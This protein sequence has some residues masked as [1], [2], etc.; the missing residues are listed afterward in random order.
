M[1]PR[2]PLTIAVTVIAYVVTTFAVQGTSHFAINA[3]HYHAI[4][5]MRSEPIVAMGLLSMVIQGLL[6]ALLFPTF[7]RG[8]NPVRSG[9]LFSWAL[10]GFL[11]S[12][13]VLGEAG[14]YAVPSISSWI[15]VEL[16]VALV[17]YTV[18]GAL[19]GFI[20]RGSTSPVLQEQRA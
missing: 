17:Q 4:P 8:A 13:I 11:A 5:I 18:F 3:D 20:H 10:G 2:K 15:I 9:I 14:K 16:S 19:L 6:F 7:N 12:Y 1:Q